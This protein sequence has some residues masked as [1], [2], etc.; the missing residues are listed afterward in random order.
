MY[1]G[2]GNYTFLFMN[3]AGMGGFAQL[4]YECTGCCQRVYISTFTAPP[5]FVYPRPGLAPCLSAIDSP[6]VLRFFF[7]FQFS[8]PLSSYTAFKKLCRGQ[9]HTSWLTP[10]QFQQLRVK[11]HAIL[12]RAAR[13]Q[14]LYA[15]E[16]MKRAHARTGLAVIGADGVYL[17]RGHDS[18]HMTGVVYDHVSQLMLSVIH[19]SRDRNLD[20]SRYLTAKVDCSS[21][22]M[23]KEVTC[24]NLEYL[25]A[26]GCPMTH[27]VFDGD[28]AIKSAVLTVVM[29]LIIVQ[30]FNHYLKNRTKDILTAIAAKIPTAL[31]AKAPG[32]LDSENHCVCQGTTH[33][34]T[35][36][37]T[38]VKCGCPN[39][40]LATKLQA[41]IHAAAISARSHQ[42]SS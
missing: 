14:C 35:A 17:I 22:T 23:E 39:D 10:P 40:S 28:S 6:D 13:R 16:H 26:L 7:G 3:T 2:D 11:L 24:A 37:A 9:G 38:K 29:A 36:T 42:G 19:A 27:G 31:S 20:E 25:V 12:S 8:T 33:V 4:V 1:A 18:P 32:R 5:T 15:I 30:C 41:Q 34:R 21:K